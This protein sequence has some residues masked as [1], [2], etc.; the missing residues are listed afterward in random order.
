MIVHKR[1]AA[2]RHMVVRH[3]KA[4]RADQ[5]R[6]HVYGPLP[7]MWERRSVR[8]A[9]HPIVA[10][11]FAQCG[12]VRRARAVVFEARSLAHGPVAWH[13]VGMSVEAAA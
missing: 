1:C 2:R 3:A 13:P 8:R 12:E 4:V 9:D 6:G 7:E 11:R 10:F 5:L